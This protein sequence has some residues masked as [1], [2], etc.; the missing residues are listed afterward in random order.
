[1]TDVIKNVNSVILPFA[2]VLILF[3]VVQASLFLAH[4]LKFN[5][6]HELFTREEVKNAMKSSVIGS[7]GPSFSIIVVVLA[8]IS[9]IGPAVTW[10]RSGVIG[11]A[12][13]E[14]WMADIVATSLDVQ[15]GGPD[16]TESLFTV[17]IF[18]MVL[19]SAPWMLHLLLTCKPLDKAVIKSSSKK[20]SFIPLLGFSAELGMMAYWALE[21][22]T[23][24]VPQT[25]G[26]VT[27]LIAGA[28]VVIYCKRGNHPKLS[29][30]ILGI[31]MIVGM[32]CSTIVAHLLPV[33]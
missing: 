29:N 24:G 3:V 12:D 23:K 10:M 26:I 27:S 2:V 11:A 14:L 31:A 4:A 9:I 15:L 16:V 18:G 22:G 7:I 5:K 17:A 33:S 30:W 28:A 13:F 6:K 21:N 19:G 32:T 8:M 20:R 25:T 1:M